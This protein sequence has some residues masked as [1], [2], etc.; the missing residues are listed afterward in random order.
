M[1]ELHEHLSEFATGDHVT[2]VGVDTRGHNV[3]RSGYLLAAAKK[4][5]AQRNGVRTDGWRLY[6]G[7]T[8]TDS[9]ERSTWVTLFRDAGS[10][11]RS[12][13]PD[14]ARWSMTE[15]RQIP[16]I[17]ATSRTTHILY[18]GKGGAHFPEPSQA[19][20]VTVIYTS[21]GLYELRSPDD[22]TVHLACRLPTQI[23]WTELP[24]TNAS[25][26]A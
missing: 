8:G 11:E 15:L 1:T 5:K 23:W 10:I 7:P 2:V 6:V 13:E 21:D 24:T 14:T 26:D 4:V 20:A 3:T 25:P 16:G 12:T 17:R 18:G 9:A 22:D 19:T